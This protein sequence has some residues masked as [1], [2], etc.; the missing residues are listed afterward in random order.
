MLYSKRHG[1]KIACKCF[2]RGLPSKSSVTRHLPTSRT[3]RVSR[4]QPGSVSHQRCESRQQAEEAAEQSRGA[5]GR[6]GCGV[7]L[8][9]W[10]GGELRVWCGS[11]L[12]AWCGGQLADL[13]LDGTS[14]PTILLLPLTV[15][16]VGAHAG[17]VRHGVG[18]VVLLLDAVKEVR[19]GSACQH[20]HVLAA[21]GG[22]LGGDG[23][24]RDVVFALWETDGD[25][26]LVLKW[27][28]LF[29]PPALRQLQIKWTY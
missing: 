6:P 9:A 12:G 15:P 22:G 26:I 4:D 28:A 8:G 27:A 24:Q 20:G 29:F 10:C 19:H 2:R 7:E 1:F 3:W 17:G 23:S 18:Y 13:G 5:A 21:V 14:N 11:E 25:I 16:Q